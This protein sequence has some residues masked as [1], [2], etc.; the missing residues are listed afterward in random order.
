MRPP[1]A[2]S[3][4]F[5]RSSGLAPD[6]SSV[7][8]LRNP[9]KNE[10]REGLAWSFF[11]RRSP[12]PCDAEPSEKRRS[13][14]EREC[15]S[16][17]LSRCARTLAGDLR[18]DG[19]ASSS[20]VLPR[21]RPGLET[22]VRLRIVIPWRC[23]SFRFCREWLE[24]TSMSGRVHT[25]GNNHGLSREELDTATWSDPPSCSSPAIV[26]TKGSWLFNTQT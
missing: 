13:L 19:M 22:S 16:F 20:K 21:C 12:F 9:D 2:S 11:F 18:V 5:C 15:S 3:N 10:G 8:R 23:L 25:E 17:L 1:V 4:F 6:Q 7:L 24:T 26:S 14:E